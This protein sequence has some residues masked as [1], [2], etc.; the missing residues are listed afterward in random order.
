M[1]NGAE[2]AAKKY[3]VNLIYQAPTNFDM[4]TMAQMIDA[5]TAT[6]PHGLIVPVP[7]LSLIH[8]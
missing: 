2:A 3:G 5:V 8:I 4:V 7:D 6:A 1:K